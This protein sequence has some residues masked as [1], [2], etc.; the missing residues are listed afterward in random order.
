MVRKFTSKTGGC[1]N[2]R[3]HVPPLLKY[4]PCSPRIDLSA[5]LGLLAAA[6]N[7]RRKSQ[8]ETH[9]TWKSVSQSAE[10]Q[11]TYPNLRLA[12]RKHAIDEGER[13]K[14]R[15]LRRVKTGAQECQ[16]HEQMY[17]LK[18]VQKGAKNH[19][20]RTRNPLKQANPSPRKVQKRVKNGPQK[21][22]LK[23]RP[24]M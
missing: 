6:I 23:I 2:R 20:R 24:K 10:E 18:E 7:G 9:A 17:V 4:S 14:D 3:K 22:H 15:N 16:N 1:I 11:L 12:T 21:R 13:L 8:R 19:L 5:S